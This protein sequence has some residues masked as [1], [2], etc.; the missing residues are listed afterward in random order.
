MASLLYVRSV[1]SLLSSMCTI[2]RMVKKAKEKGYSSIGLVDKNV[3]SGAMSFY[4]E[5]LKENIKP[6]IG[7]EVYVNVDRIVSVILYANGDKFGEQVY[8]DKDKGVYTT[9]DSSG[10]DKCI[11][12]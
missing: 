10:V 9:S 8:W 6:V 11:T 1:Y 5:C 2:P 7:L 12:P 4:N 3:L